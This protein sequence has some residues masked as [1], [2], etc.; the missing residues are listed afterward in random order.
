[1]PSKK[2]RLHSYTTQLIVDKFKVVADS[3][4]R[5]SS[6]ELEFIVKEHI[7][8]FEKENGEIKFDKE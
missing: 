2:P 1:M 7:K 4:S 8:N 6:K 5:S 3:N